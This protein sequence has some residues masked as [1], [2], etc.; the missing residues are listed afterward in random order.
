MKIFKFKALLLLGLFILIAGFCYDFM[1]AGLP[2]QDPT[3]EQYAYW[4]YHGNIAKVIVITGLIL[5]ASAIV[6]AIF[7]ALFFTKQ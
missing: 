2:Y 1:F 4:S 5:I 7:R 6:T 3:A